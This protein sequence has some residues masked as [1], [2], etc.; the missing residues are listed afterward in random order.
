MNLT[1][2]IFGDIKKMFASDSIGLKNTMT[3]NI[4]KVHSIFIAMKKSSV[5][6]TLVSGNKSALFRCP[7][8][9][10]RFVH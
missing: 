5:R 3:E 8:P 4:H 6:L 9:L 1:A 7:H 10:N 2:N